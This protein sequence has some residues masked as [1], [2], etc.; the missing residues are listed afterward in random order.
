MG[1]WSQWGSCSKSCVDPYE[2]FG[3]QSRNRTCWPSINGGLDCSYH[4][5]LTETR[6][7]KKVIFKLLHNVIIL[8]GHV[9][10]MTCFQPIVQSLHLGVS[11]LIGMIVM[12]LV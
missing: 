12:H 6:Y 11:G 8:V 7:I 4:G 5:D 9:L 3:H 10:E 2:R 1:Q